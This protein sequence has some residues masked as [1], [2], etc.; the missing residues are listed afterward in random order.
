MLESRA[1]ILLAAVVLAWVAIRWN[2]KRTGP[3]LRTEAGE[4]ARRF[5]PFSL[6]SLGIVYSA[7]ALFN[8]TKMTFGN[9]RMAFPLLEHLFLWALLA[10]AA[11]FSCQC[12]SRYAARILVMAGLLAALSPQARNWV[13]RNNSEAK[14]VYPDLEC[15]LNEASPN[16]TPVVCFGP[17]KIFNT[18]SRFV[19]PTLYARRRYLQAAGTEIPQDC[20][21]WISRP[22]VVPPETGNFEKV[23]EYQVQTDLY[24]VYRKR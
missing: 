12:I 8:P 2:A 24:Y 19:A 15:L 17:E 16:A 6:L 14:T 10:L 11:T 18:F 5:G 3:V 22:A 1:I 21:V 20:S 23:R 4:F 13:P 7:I 9:P